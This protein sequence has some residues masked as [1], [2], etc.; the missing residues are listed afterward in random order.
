[1]WFG[2]TCIKNVY[3]WQQKREKKKVTCSVLNFKQYG[4]SSEE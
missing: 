2:F 3:I 4:Y 1:M